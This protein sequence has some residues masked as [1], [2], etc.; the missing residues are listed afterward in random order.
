MRSSTEPIKSLSLG[1]AISGSPVI[2]SI[3]TFIPSSGNLFL[4]T[5]KNLKTLI[6]G[7]LLG[8][9][10]LSILGSKGFVRNLK[11]SKSRKIKRNPSSKRRLTS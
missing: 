6:R 4:E 9:I 3:F 5:K 1:L 10:S 7:V 2:T 8:L 11:A